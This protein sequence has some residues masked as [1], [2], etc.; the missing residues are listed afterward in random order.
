MNDYGATDFDALHAPPVPPLGYRGLRVGELIEVDGEP[1]RVVALAPS[2]HACERGL[3]CKAA[4]QPL[5]M[6]AEVVFDA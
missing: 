1:F 6:P 2:D 5:L 4:W 3:A